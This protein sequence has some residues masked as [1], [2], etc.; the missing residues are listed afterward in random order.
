MAAEV[1]W[2]GDEEEATDG[3]TA[4]CG[5]TG[6]DASASPYTHSVPH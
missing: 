1:R 2:M 4:G 5:D 3:A 6:M